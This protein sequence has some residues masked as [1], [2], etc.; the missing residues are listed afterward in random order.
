MQMTIVLNRLIIGP[1]QNT[2]F[3]KKINDKWNWTFRN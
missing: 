1:W 2:S 3:N